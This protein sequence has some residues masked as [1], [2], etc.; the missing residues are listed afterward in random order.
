MLAGFPKAP[1]ACADAS[2]VICN[3]ATIIPEKYMAELIGKAKNGF[4]SENAQLAA[5]S[6]IPLHKVTPG[7]VLVG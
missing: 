5:N 2:H 6:D 7:A 1:C 4:G 3:K